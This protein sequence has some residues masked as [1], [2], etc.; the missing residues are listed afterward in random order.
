[1]QGPTSREITPQEVAA[2]TGRDPQGPYTKT[3]DPGQFGADWDQPESW[4]YPG[5][6][7]IRPQTRVYQIIAR[8]GK[9]TGRLS[10]AKDEVHGAALRQETRDAKGNIYLP[11]AVLVDVIFDD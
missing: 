9:P 4:Y 10:Y 1:M 3:W 8:D 11:G 5:T 7:Q 2:L 6:E